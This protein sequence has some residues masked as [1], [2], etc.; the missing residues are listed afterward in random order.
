M[1]CAAMAGEMDADP[2]S[3]GCAAPR[4]GRSVLAISTT[5]S[6]E[7]RKVAGQRFDRRVAWAGSAAIQLQHSGAGRGE[8][9][10]SSRIPL[11][12][13]G[14][15]PRPPCGLRRRRPSRPAKLELGHRRSR[16]E[17]TNL[18]SSTPFLARPRAWRRPMSVEMEV[19]EAGG[20]GTPCACRRPVRLVQT[21]CL[22]AW[23]ADSKVS[24]AWRGRRAP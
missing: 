14:T 6:R 13:Q 20:V 17:C 10:P 18:R 12:T 9:P 2:P 1:F 19:D 8:R 22:R 5:Y 4:P 11:A 3:T 21:R 23:R 24:P 15:T 7:N 16:P